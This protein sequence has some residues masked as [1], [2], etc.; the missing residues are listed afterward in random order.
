M[1][2][3]RRPLKKRTKNKTLLA[4]PIGQFHMCSR[5]TSQTQTPPVAKPQD[6]AMEMG[7][8]ARY[9]ASR[10]AKDAP[11]I[12]P[13]SIGLRPTSVGAVRERKPGLELRPVAG[14]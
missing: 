14:S 1:S 11:T 12:T 9:E 8:Q 4:R 2:A 5:T 13:I 10:T 7:H 6:S 3:N